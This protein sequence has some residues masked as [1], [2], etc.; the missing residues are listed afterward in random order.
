ME[1]EKLKVRAGRNRTVTVDSNEVDEL[2]QYITDAADVV[3]D[4]D[5]C[6]KMINGD[7]LGVIDSILGSRIRGVSPLLVSQGVR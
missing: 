2:R 5:F 3:P 4:F 6:D 7:L 1:N